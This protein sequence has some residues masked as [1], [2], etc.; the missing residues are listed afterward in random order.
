MELALCSMYAENRP[1]VENRPKA[2]NDGFAKKI[3]PI[4]SC[5]WVWPQ[6]EIGLAHVSPSYLYR[7]LFSLSYL[8]LLSTYYSETSFL[9]LK[10]RSYI[11]AY[12]KTIKI[13]WTKL[14]EPSLVWRG[15]NISWIR[16]WFHRSVFFMRMS[17]IES[18]LLSKGYFRPYLIS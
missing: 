7:S 16:C 6:T 8:T 9:N 5:G 2:E 14:R 1:K 12:S 4:T 17:A 3:R 11:L 15:W 18:L 13:N 10:A